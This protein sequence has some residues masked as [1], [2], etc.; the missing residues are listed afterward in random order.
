MF[1][2]IGSEI[3]HMLE[4]TDIWYTAIAMRRK[5]L[6]LT[7]GSRWFGRRLSRN[8]YV[9]KLLFKENPWPCRLLNGSCMYACACSL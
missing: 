7:E 2:L 9:P 6:Q 8:D 4:K 5:L 1:K 3:K